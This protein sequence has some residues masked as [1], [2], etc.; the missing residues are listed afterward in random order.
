MNGS[1]HGPNE[2]MAA[3]I[4]LDVEGGGRLDDDYDAGWSSS[5]GLAW[6]AKGPAAY[7]SSMSVLQSAKCHLTWARAGWSDANRWLEAVRLSSR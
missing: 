5:S 6:S 7:A 3:S 4:D 1:R 2:S